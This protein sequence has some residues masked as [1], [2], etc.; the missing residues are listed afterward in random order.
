MGDPAMSFDVFLQCFV[1]GKPGSIPVAEVR[2]AFGE[3][4][5]ADD[6]GLW[7]VYYDGENSSDIYMS[8]LPSDSSRISGFCVNRPCGDERLWESLLSVMRMGSVVMYWPGS[9]PLVADESV[10]RQLPSEMIEAI[11]RPI[12]VCSTSEILGHLRTT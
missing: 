2:K 12:L 8:F 4:L 10:E 5:R 6:P 1:G 3:H 9:R 11:G 7:Q